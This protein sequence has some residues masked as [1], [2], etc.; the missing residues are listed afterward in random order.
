MRGAESRIYQVL[1]ATLFTVNFSAI[2]KA[3][4]WQ[5]ADDLFARRA[6]S[7]AIIQQARA[8][9]PTTAPVQ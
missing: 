1:F 6:E 2:A 8:K 7:R 3:E 5:E 4:I 9:Y